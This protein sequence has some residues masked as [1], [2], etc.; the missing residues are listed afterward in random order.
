MKCG[1]T[2]RS[3]I[4]SSDLLNSR[5][6]NPSCPFLVV[7][8]VTKKPWNTPGLKARPKGANL[9]EDKTNVIFLGGVGLGKTHLATALGYAACLKGKSVLFTTAID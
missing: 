7:P 2:K 5:G 1:S 9:I 3:S 8:T 6:E 4:L